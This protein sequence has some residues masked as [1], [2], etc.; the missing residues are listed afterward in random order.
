MHKSKVNFRNFFVHFAERPGGENF[1]KR[2]DFLKF[3]SWRKCT[4]GRKE[5][6][7]VGT[8]THPKREVRGAICFR[9]PKL[10]PHTV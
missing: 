8:K 1:L 6:R 5:K 2:L 4:S 9:K 10:Y 7:G 3:R